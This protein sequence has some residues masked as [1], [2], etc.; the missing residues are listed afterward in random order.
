MSNKLDGVGNVGVRKFVHCSAQFIYLINKRNL[1]QTRLQ[2]ITQGEQNPVSFLH[3]AFVH[4]VDTT[5]FENI[6]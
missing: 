6:Y 2:N 5:L 3:K 4:P 1:S